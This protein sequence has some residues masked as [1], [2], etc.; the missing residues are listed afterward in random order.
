MGKELKR[1]NSCVSISLAEDNGNMKE[2]M[3][4]IWRDAALVRRD[5]KEE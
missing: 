5:K 2:V 1:M 4:R 3:W